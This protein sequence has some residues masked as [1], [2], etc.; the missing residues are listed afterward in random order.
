MAGWYNHIVRLLTVIIVSSTCLARPA[1]AEQP[2][3]ITVR[4]G[5]TVAR[6]VG[7]AMGVRCDDPELVH[8]EMRNTDPDTNVFVVTGRKP[9]TTICRAGTY[10]VENRQTF[11]FEVTVLAKPR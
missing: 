5:Q 2:E 8:A 9:G 11:L 7:W 3:S 1:L 6:E 4:V 10:H